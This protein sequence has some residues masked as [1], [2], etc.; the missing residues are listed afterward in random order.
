MRAVVGGSRGVDVP[1]AVRGYARL[2][3]DMREARTVLSIVGQ[4]T[5]GPLVGERLVGER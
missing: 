5:G 3:A 4:A 2:C 1:A